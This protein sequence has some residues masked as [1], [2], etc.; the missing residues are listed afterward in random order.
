MASNMGF[1]LSNLFGSE[2]LKLVLSHSILDPPVIVFLDSLHV[3]GP[4]CYF[5]CRDGLPWKT[6]FLCV[7]FP[8]AVGCL[9]AAGEDSPFNRVEV[10]GTMDDAGVALR[11]IHRDILFL[12]HDRDSSF[13]LVSKSLR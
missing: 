1:E 8:H 9:R 13:V 12:F 11:C 10:E 7:G 5:Q 4:R 6:T 3:L 2:N